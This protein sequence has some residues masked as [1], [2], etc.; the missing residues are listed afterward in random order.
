MIYSIFIQKLDEKKD[1]V[2]SAVRTVTGSVISEIDP[3][4][5][6]KTSAL[7]SNFNLNILMQAKITDYKNSIGF[8]KFTIYVVKYRSTLK[9]NL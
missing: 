6:S 8:Y 3:F 1:G 4:S 9:F 2:Y 7:V 5:F